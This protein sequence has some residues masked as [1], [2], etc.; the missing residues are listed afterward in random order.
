MT[1]LPNFSFG[2]NRRLAVS[3]RKPRQAPFFI[4]PT[5]FW[6]P[7]RDV[8]LTLMSSGLGFSWGRF[9][10]E[11][12]VLWAAPRPFSPPL[13]P[14]RAQDLAKRIK[15]QFGVQVDPVMLRQAFGSQ[16][17]LRQMHANGVE[18]TPCGLRLAMEGAL[19]EQNAM[20]GIEAKGADRPRVGRVQGLRDKTRDGAS[21][22][23][24]SD[25]AGGYQPDSSVFDALD[26]STQ[27]AQ[28]HWGEE[29]ETP[30]TQSPDNKS[31]ER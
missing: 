22:K 18:S 28:S 19:E 24:S 27:E 3:W 26:A 15:E 5:F 4:F 6:L 10:C 25:D 8:S 12:Q 7:K 20:K 13:E 11:A 9:S 2:K 16:R 17:H 30:M 29:T 1:R 31:R 23:P 14:S 21:R